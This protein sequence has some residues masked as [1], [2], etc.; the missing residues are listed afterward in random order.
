MARNK[1]GMFPH[2]ERFQ[3]HYKTRRKSLIKNAYFSRARVRR[4]MLPRRG[5]KTLCM[6]LFPLLCPSLFSRYPSSAVL[7]FLL[8]R[9]FYW[10]DFATF[11]P[12]HEIL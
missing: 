5:S 11:T 3:A 2:V 9:K 4:E 6:A 10:V 7:C 12:K 8:L 1:K